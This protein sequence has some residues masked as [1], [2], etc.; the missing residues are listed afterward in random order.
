MSGAWLYRRGDRKTSSFLRLSNA[1]ASALWANARNSPRQQALFTQSVP[2]DCAGRVI[3]AGKTVTQTAPIL[4]QRSYIMSDKRRLDFA[5]AGI[6]SPG[7]RKSSR[8]PKVAIAPSTA[9]AHDPFTHTTTGRRIDARIG[10]FVLGMAATGL[11]AVRCLGREGISVKGFDTSARRPG[12][13][14][15][16]CKAEVCPDPHQQPEDL[17]RFLNHQVK[18]GSQKVVLLP[19]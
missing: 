1:P 13:W 19:T 12:F 8:S 3:A 10:A 4:Y 17:V 5:P 14:S 18:D 7:L 2:S 11:T 6:A 15:R 16:Y 9:R